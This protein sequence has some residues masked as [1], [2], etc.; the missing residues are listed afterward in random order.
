MTAKKSYL[1]EIP[2]EEQVLLGS[3][4][5]LSS[6]GIEGL[7]LAMSQIPPTL[8]QESLVAQLKKN[9]DLASVSDLEGI[10]SA[11]INVAGTAYSAGA[12]TDDI[13]NA[14]VATMKDD[15]VVELSDAEAEA[16][17]ERLKRLERLRPLELLAK[18]SQLIKAS[19]RT[20]LSAKIYSDLRPIFVGEEA[21]VAGAVV[22]HQFAVRSV[23]NARREYTYFMLDSTDLAE[24]QEVISRAIKKDKALRDLAA[25]STTPVLSPPM[26]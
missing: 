1:L 14:A 15:D 25:C 18:G 8:V 10:L 24:L 22:V 21:Q 2:K 17:K 19:E 5:K 12:S 20:F 26:E 3:V 9:P 4:L 13:V 23:R 11:L 16:L 6:S 7:E